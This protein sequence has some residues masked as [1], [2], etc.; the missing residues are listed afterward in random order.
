[1]KTSSLAQLKKEHY[2]RT[3][4]SFISL[5][6]YDLY[7]ANRTSFMLNF[8]SIYPQYI[9]SFSTIYLCYIDT[10]VFISFWN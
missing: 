3:V 8:M 6:N 1:M 2:R 4:M 10:W 9:S 7:H 5:K